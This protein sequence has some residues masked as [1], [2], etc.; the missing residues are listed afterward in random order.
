MSV[1]FCEI[2]NFG[3]IIVLEY[4]LKL[5]RVVID[6]LLFSRG[7]IFH[8]KKHDT[9]DCVHNLHT[10]NMPISEC[11]YKKILIK[12]IKALVIITNILV[13]PF[14]VYLICII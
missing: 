11:S 1:Y 6:E 3:N 14:H 10:A 9:F 5:I 2:V 7:F 13:I 8:T 12:L 4:N